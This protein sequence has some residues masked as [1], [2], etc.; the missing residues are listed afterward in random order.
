MHVAIHQASRVL[1][2]NYLYLFQT[3][4]FISV[5]GQSLGSNITQKKKWT[6]QSWEGC[7]SSL[8]A[9]RWYRETTCLMR[10]RFESNPLSLCFAV[11][12]IKLTNW[13]G[14][15][16]LPNKW[17]L[18]FPALTLVIASVCLTRLFAN[19]AQWWKDSL[20]LSIP[21]VKT[22]QNVTRSRP[23]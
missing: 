11:V 19:T 2:S 9:W 5:V 3:R 7:S 16:F 23:I 21:G 20:F 14:E 12:A 6:A 4:V 22:K 15:Q 13:L 1:V 8:Y 10:L 17:C 18:A